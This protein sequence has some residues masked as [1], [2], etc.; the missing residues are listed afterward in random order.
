MSIAVESLVPNHATLNGAMES[1]EHM[2]ELGGREEVDEAAMDDNASDGDGQSQKLEPKPENSETP[3]ITEAPAKEESKLATMDPK[4]TR[5]Y[6]DAS[7]TMKHHLHICLKFVSLMYQHFEDR[8]KNASIEDY[9]KDDQYLRVVMLNSSLLKA[10]H[11]CESFQAHCVREFPEVSFDFDDPLTSFDGTLTTIYEGE[12]LCSA[13]E[14][15]PVPS[16]H[17]RCVDGRCA[18]RDADGQAEVKLREALDKIRDMEKSLDEQV[19]HGHAREKELQDQIE[20]L[21]RMHHERRLE[22]IEVAPG[23]MVSCERDEETVSITNTELQRF[24]SI[25]QNLSSAVELARDQEAAS[26][27][28]EELVVQE[29]AETLRILDDCNKATSSSDTATNATKGNGQ[30]VR[31]PESLAHKVRTLVE[32]KERLKVELRRA[33]R[34]ASKQK[35]DEDYDIMAMQYRATK[36]RYDN[37]AQKFTELAH[38]RLAAQPKA[39]R[40]SCSAKKDESVTPQR[41]FL[42]NPRTPAETNTSVLSART[43]GE[44][45]DISE[46]DDFDLRRRHDTKRRVDL[47]NESP[48]N[49]IDRVIEQLAPSPSA[50]N[51]QRPAMVKSLQMPLEHRYRSS[52]C[53]RREE[54]AWEK[55]VRRATTKS[56]SAAPPI[57]KTVV[58]KSTFEPPT[59]KHVTPTPQLTRPPMNLPLR[60][61]SPHFNETTRLTTPIAAWPSRCTWPGR[62]PEKK[63]PN[64]YFKM[65]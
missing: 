61:M 65:T 32:E 50:P 55:A 43:N 21:E 10:L 14:R 44:T 5:N 30:N 62:E 34:V 24:A 8:I 25:M 17:P 48:G 29:M 11:V 19:A 6:A 60:S 53:G 22:Q 46:V 57:Q 26:K 45:P 59:R 58:T 12:D 7:Q 18:V 20:Q 40:R 35:K 52:S 31:A 36:L 2:G 9:E 47:E 16:E 1:G 49:R 15:H 64:I 51:L 33:K 3:E 41:A 54:T 23:V 4:L 27:L 39:K 13:T 56:H 63:G 42:E 37:L 28:K 38:R